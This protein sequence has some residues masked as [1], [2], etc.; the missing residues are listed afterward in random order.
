[1]LAGARPFVS[2]VFDG[3]RKPF[4]AFLSR[5]AEKRKMNVWLRASRGSADVRN[6]YFSRALFKSRSA[7]GKHAV[8]LK[9]DISLR[10]MALRES[11]VG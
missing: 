10:V 7:E 8:T 1:M 4:S 5:F 9:E 6:D 11:T 3:I 2:I